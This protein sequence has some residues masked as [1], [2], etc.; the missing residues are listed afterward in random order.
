MRTQ[1]LL[2]AAVLLLVVAGAA[3][4][5]GP[6]GVEAKARAKKEREE[7]MRAVELAQLRLKVSSLGACVLLLH[8]SARF[9]SGVRVP[10]VCAAASCGFARHFDGVY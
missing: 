5:V 10:S 3:A 1:R 4:H 8:G 7:L 2:A 6:E 9:G